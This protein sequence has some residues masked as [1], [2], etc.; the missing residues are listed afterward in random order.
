MPLNLRLAE[1]SDSPIRTLLPPSNPTG[2]N[3]PPHLPPLPNPSGTHFTSSQ[4]WIRP[5][6]AP[7]MFTCGLCRKS[8]NLRPAHKGP[9]LVCL[10]FHQGFHTQLSLHPHQPILAGDLTKLTLSFSYDT[11]S[12]LYPLPWKLWNHSPPLLLHRGKRSQQ[13]VPLL[14]LLPDTCLAR[15]SLARF[16]PPV[17]RKAVTIPPL[18]T[19]PFCLPRTLNLQVIPLSSVPSISLS[20]APFPSAFPFSSL[21]LKK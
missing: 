17:M 15:L 16:A 4:P 7:S 20:T 11:Y 21:H 14:F 12:E 3:G 18:D 5:L 19:I 8:H 6:S 1:S 9:E 13:D 2:H 10:N